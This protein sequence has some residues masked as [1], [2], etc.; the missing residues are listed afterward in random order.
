[1]M[2]LTAITIISWIKVMIQNDYYC[3][4]SNIEERREGNIQAKAHLKTRKQ[5]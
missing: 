1:M 2:C 4:D 5:S 3:S